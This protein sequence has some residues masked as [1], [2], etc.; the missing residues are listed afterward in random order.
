MSA[1]KE[2]KLN[3]SNSTEKARQHAAN[4]FHSL[5][6]ARAQDREIEAHEVSLFSW[7]LP[8]AP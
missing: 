6:T 8:T 1:N 7:V 2:S 5:I 4:L 3:R